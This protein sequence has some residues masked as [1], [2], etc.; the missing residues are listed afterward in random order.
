V[1]CSD[2]LEAVRVPGMKT[3]SD[4]FI[5]V[6]FTTIGLTDYSPEADSST[7]NILNFDSWGLDTQVI[8]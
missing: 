6:Q 2:A 7:G 4:K 8:S 1:I 3:G 5:K